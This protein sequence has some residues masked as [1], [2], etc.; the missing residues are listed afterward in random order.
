MPAVNA[1]P[2]FPRISQICGSEEV[3]AAICGRLLP[4]AAMIPPATQ[5]VAILPAW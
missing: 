3:A 1:K 2:I 4:I 5:Y